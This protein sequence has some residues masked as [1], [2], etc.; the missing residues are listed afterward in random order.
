MDR[1]GVRWVM[2]SSLDRGGQ[3]DE[4]LGFD[5]LPGSHVADVVE[6]GGAGNQLAAPVRSARQ[7]KTRMS[8][9]LSCLEHQH[10]PPNDPSQLF[11]SVSYDTYDSG[12]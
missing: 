9:V 4:A 10:L 2:I 1:M 6:I 5:R 7:N 12:I 11:A 3:I 8:L